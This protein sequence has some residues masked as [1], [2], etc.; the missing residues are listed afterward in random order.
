MKE[1][2]INGKKTD[3]F[4]NGNIKEELFYVDDLRNG[5]NKTYYENG[6]IE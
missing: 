6:N 1:D 4:E 5:K 3:Y 2:K